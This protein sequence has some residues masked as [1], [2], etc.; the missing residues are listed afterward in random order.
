MSTTIGSTLSLSPL[1]TAS[2]TGTS[3][4]QSQLDPIVGGLI[5]AIVTVIAMAIL[6]LLVTRNGGKPPFRPCFRRKR[7]E[8]LS[9]E[10]NQ[11]KSTRRSRMKPLPDYHPEADGPSVPK[12]LSAEKGLLLQENELQERIEAL[13]AELVQC[14]Y[15]LDHNL[16][17]QEASS[18]TSIR[19]SDS[20][21]RIHDPDI[22]NVPQISRHMDAL[23]TRIRHWEEQL[24]LASGNRSSLS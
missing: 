1:P 4:K 14:H 7:R 3:P 22:T 9:T 2:F 24:G 23:R 6:I 10:V 13:R 20:A 21:S 12:L 8:N 5:G 16:P 18:V 17:W 19:P 15:F 11:Q